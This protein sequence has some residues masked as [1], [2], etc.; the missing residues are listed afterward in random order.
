MNPPPPSSV[1]PSPKSESAR[2]CATGRL[3]RRWADEPHQGDDP[4]HVR[5]GCVWVCLSPS[6][7]GTGVWW[8]G[9]WAWSPIC[10][11]TCLAT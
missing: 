2:T 10:P 3:S 1:F 6:R 9:C 8:G 11:N 4:E 7:C 5:Y